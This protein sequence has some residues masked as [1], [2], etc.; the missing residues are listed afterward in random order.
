MS[1]RSTLFWKSSAAILGLSSAGEKLQSLC[2]ILLKKRGSEP[3]Q[4]WISRF[5]HSTTGKLNNPSQ[6]YG[7]Y[8]HWVLAWFHSHLIILNASKNVPSPKPEGY[9]Y[10]MILANV[11]CYRRS[12]ISKPTSVQNNWN[13][14]DW[15]AVKH[16]LKLYWWHMGRGD[17]LHCSRSQA[18]RFLSGGNQNIHY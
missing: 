14:R 11:T 10:L 17:L 7:H 5:C 9:E 3:P 18:N 13:F 6:S 4:C 12:A 15:A 1:P 2:C 8:R 16:V